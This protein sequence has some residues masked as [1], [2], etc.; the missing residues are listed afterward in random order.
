[1][2]AFLM[3]TADIIIVPVGVFF[4][5]FNRRAIKKERREEKEKRRKRRRR[6]GKRRREKKEEKRET[7]KQFHFTNSISL[8][9]DIGHYYVSDGPIESSEDTNE[10]PRR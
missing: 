1:M 9:H 3:N 8:S 7:E 5:C 2:M 10:Q 4:W 6:G